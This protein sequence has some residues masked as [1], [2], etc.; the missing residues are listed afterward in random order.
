MF[1]KKQLI[2]IS[3]C[4]FFRNAVYRQFRLMFANYPETHFPI[5]G[6]LL[7]IQ[8]SSNDMIKQRSAVSGILSM[9]TPS[10]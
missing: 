6:I 10:L 4:M 2:I 8:T 1:L 5:N 9:G 3:D 7:I